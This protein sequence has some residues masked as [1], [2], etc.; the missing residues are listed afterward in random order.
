MKRKSRGQNLS[1]NT[2]YGNNADQVL[3]EVG[4]F[5]DPKLGELREEFEYTI[6]ERD[7]SVFGRARLNHETRNCVWP[8]QTEDGRKWRARNGEDEIFPWEGA[9]DAR[10]ALTEL[11]VRKH[12]AFLLVLWKR[13]R[14]QVQGTEANDAAWANRMTTL[15]RWMKYT[16]MS[17]NRAETEL[18]LNYLCE[19]GSAVKGCFWSRRSQ[20]A[21]QELDL[22]GLATMA[23]QRAQSGDQSFLQLPAMA[24]D[25]SM[26][27]EAA[28]LL[29]EM[30]KAESGNQKAEM[31]EETE[32]EVLPSKRLEA[33][34]SDL[35]LNGFARFPRPVVTMNRPKVVAY[36][37]NED[38]FISPDA[39]NGLDDA[40]V[41][42]VEVVREAK[43]RG[44]ARDYGWDPAWTEE[45]VETQRGNV[46]FSGM[47][48]NQRLS[49]Q[50]SYLLPARG[51]LD[52]RKQYLLVHSYRRLADEEG[53]EGIYYT[54]WNPHLSKT[55]NRKQ[56]AEK[57]GYA[58]H[59]L[60]NYDHGKMPF[61][62]YV[63]ERRSRKI[64]DARGYGEQASTWQAQ[65]KAEWDNRIDRAS[66]AT[67]PPSHYPNGEQP[68][69]WGPG[70]Q[71]PT[72]RPDAYGFFEVPGDPRG[73]EEVEASVRQFADE[74]FGE[75][76]D[77]LHIN[78][79]QT[80]KQKLADSFMEGEQGVDTQC[81]QLCQ[82][83][84]PDEFYFRIVG[85]AKGKPIH[86]TREE[87][88]GQFDLAVSFNVGD[89]M[90]EQL[91][92]KLGLLQQLLQMDINGICDHNEAM[93]M[94][95][96]M[97]DPNAGERLLKPA[98][99]ASQAE[100]ED[101][102]T[103][104]L[105]LLTGTSVPVKPGQAYQLRLQTLGQFLQQ[106]QVAQQAIQ[107]NPQ[108]QEAVKQRVKDLGFQLQQQQNAVTG[109][110]GPAFS[111][112]MQK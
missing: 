70:V 17:E 10:V 96:E 6:N 78:D 40:S 5:S 65:I 92:E 79:S 62:L 13:M 58:K 42:V 54:V 101:E 12:V 111:P 46:W 52:T 37:P 90:P 44:Y 2:G 73:S 72:N 49:R 83:F 56:K 38:I 39:R 71:V 28:P 35:R 99:A 69:K 26:D 30:L 61:T 68:D 32:L 25:P 59:E 55:E 11:Y 45:V 88:Q 43:L 93:V 4:S 15:L 80:L 85:S 110:G 82:Q 3:R 50:A 19:R 41:H 29:G 20:L 86:S 102:Q 22:E 60:L 66:I 104:A 33:V 77:E 64:D 108:A 8:G 91:K 74:Y 109:R 112:K 21:Y 7:S 9:S 100:V 18:L 63:T 106:S 94:A 48:F 27:A 51:Q 103:V 1:N 16:Q 97:F 105:K 53:V 84:M 23:M 107:R 89:M 81:L 57:G 95:F 34:L 75:A 24:L 47:L 14:V 76:N 36:C 67:L 31:G 98:E 87:I